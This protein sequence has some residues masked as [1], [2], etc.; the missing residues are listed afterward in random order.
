[1]IFNVNIL[2]NE[3]K[4]TVT[5]YFNLEKTSENIPVYCIGKYSYMAGSE[6]QT[7]IEL[8]IEENRLFHN[9]HIGQFVLCQSVPPL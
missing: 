1:M 8:T 5:H 7:S 4:N 3:I 6:I 2:P 9:L